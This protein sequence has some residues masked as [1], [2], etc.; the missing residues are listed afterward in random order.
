ME[1]APEPKARLLLPDDPDKSI[2]P[3]IAGDAEQTN[4]ETDNWQVA[5]KVGWRDLE[6]YD[7]QKDF[8]RA[9]GSLGVN[10]EVTGRA[11]RVGDSIHVEGSVEHW[12]HDLYDFV[13]VP[14]YGNMAAALEQ[15]GRAR[16]FVIGAGW[17]QRFTAVIEIVDGAPRIKEFRWMDT[18]ETVNWRANE[19]ARKDRSIKQEQRSRK[20]A[21]AKGREHEAE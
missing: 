8:G 18:N 17:T 12:L 11:R 21:K 4:I 15:A 3:L 1:A 10:A 19:K 9:F 13:D 2:L 5:L 7:S 14:V 6:F 20:Q 16:R